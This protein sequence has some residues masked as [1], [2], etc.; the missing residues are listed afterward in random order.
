MTLV[1]RSGDFLAAAGPGGINT[2]QYYVLLRMIAQVTG[3]KPGK[4]VHLVQN[5]HIYDRHIDMV[6]EIIEED[7]DKEGPS[8]WVNPEVKELKDFTIDDFKLE[9]YNPQDKKYNIPIAI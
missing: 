6:K 8:L 5:L 9:N 1:Q 4:F 7:S 2:F 3:F